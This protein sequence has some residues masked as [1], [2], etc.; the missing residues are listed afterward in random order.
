[1]GD[2]NIIEQAMELADDGA[3][4]LGKVTRIHNGNLLKS[5]YRHC[6]KSSCDA[7]KSW[8]ISIAKSLGVDSRWRKGEA[9]SR[10][11]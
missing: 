1:V 2:T 9:G 11:A 10:E 6:V 3:H 7:G 8:G 5:F 4:L